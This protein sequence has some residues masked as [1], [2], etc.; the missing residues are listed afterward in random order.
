MLTHSNSKAYAI[1]SI[2]M[3]E[4]GEDTKIIVNPFVN[5]RENGFVVRGYKSCAHVAFS[6]DRNSDGIVTY[7]CSDGQSFTPFGKLDDCVR[8]FH[9]GDNYVLAVG[10][11]LRLLNLRENNEEL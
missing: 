8:G 9:S 11:I 4:I 1:L 3:Y 7:F 2:L 5:G 10:Q 6:E